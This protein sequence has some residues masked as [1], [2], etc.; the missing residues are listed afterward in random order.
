MLT[1]LAN[2]PA[3]S[4]GDFI[5]KA[6][7]MLSIF[8]G[9]VTAWAVIS[10]KKQKLEQ[11]VE[12]KASTE[13][14]DKTSYHNHCKLNLE[15]HQRIEARMELITQAQGVQAQEIAA[16]KVHREN[17]AEQLDKLGEQMS[18]INRTMG[19]VHATVNHINNQ[20]TGKK[21]A[22]RAAHS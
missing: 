20:I 8:A 14:V 12:V 22:R 9:A 11:P 1:L 2:S 4:D 17:A 6:L 15:H 16:L 3:V 19:E 18:E 5:L 7:N 10:G 13:Y 21:D